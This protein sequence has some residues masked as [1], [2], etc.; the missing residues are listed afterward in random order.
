M[1]TTIGCITC[2]MQPSFRKFPKVISLGRKKSTLRQHRASRRRSDASDR[3]GIDGRPSGGSKARIGPFRRKKARDRA[4]PSVC[5]RSWKATSAIRRRQGRRALGT[6][7]GLA[8]VLLAPRL[9]DT[10]LGSRL[11]LCRNRGLG[12]GRGLGGA[13]ASGR[14]GRRFLARRNLRSRH[15][16]DRR[17][18]GLCRRGAFG[19]VLTTTTAAGPRLG[20]VRLSGDIG[21]RDRRLNGGRLGL[22]RHRG[23]REGGN[24]G[25]RRDER[26]QLADGLLTLGGRIAARFVALARTAEALL[27]AALAAALVQASAFASAFAAATLEAATVLARRTALGLELRCLHEGLRAGAGWRLSRSPR[28]RRSSRPRSSR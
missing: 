24:G 3:S 19:R 10:A 14:G 4:G 21:A 5:L 8:L 22:G 1:T 20:A 2:I 26:R 11:V 15:R 23:R 13:A 12:R 16:S 7:F 25:R 6:A 18:G 27:E 17:R 28:S 9:G